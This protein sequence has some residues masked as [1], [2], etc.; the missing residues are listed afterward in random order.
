MINRY[1][2]LSFFMLL[3]VTLTF[4]QSNVIAQG[5]TTAAMNGM[6]VDANGAPLPGANIIAVHIPSG[7]QYGTTSRVDGKFNLNGLRTGGPYTVTVSFVGYKP[8]VSEGQMLQL[9]QNLKLDFTLY[10]ETIEF[11]DITVVGEKNAILS[12]N[13]TGA[14]QNVTARDIEL[15]PSI[16]KNFGDF[17]KLSPQANG[18][19]S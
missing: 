4:M 10:D 6:V 13:R 15:I 16:S 17:A 12:T 5:V 2:L 7:T 19:S 18:N 9:G 8:Q 14:E 3:L 11:G 1:S